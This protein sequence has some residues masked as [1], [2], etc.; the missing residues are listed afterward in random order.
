[1]IVSGGGALNLTLM[2]HLVGLLAPVPVRSIAA[3]GLP[4]QAKEPVAFAFLALRALQRRPNHWPETTGA[5]AAAILGK[6]VPA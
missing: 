6:T 4:P 5:H 1:M 3:Y 2:R